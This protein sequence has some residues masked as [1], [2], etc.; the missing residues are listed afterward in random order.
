MDKYS[1]FVLTTPMFFIIYLSLGECSPGFK[2]L[3]S[4]EGEKYR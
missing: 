2:K 4:F 3:F 1:T